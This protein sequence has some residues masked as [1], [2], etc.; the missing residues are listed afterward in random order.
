MTFTKSAV[1]IAEP[2]AAL[3]L[4]LRM[5]AVLLLLRPQGP[6]AVFVAWLATGSLAVLVPAALRSGLLWYVAAAVVATRIAFDWPLADNHMYLLAYWCLAIGLALGAGSPAATLRDAGRWLL[7]GAFGLAVVWKAL[8][9]P[10]FIDGRFFRVTLVVDE[11]FEDVVRLAGG[12]GRDE[13]GRHRAALAPVPPGAELAPDES[14]VEPPQLHRLARVLTIAGLLMEAAVAVGFLLPLPGRWQWARHAL[15]LVFCAA[16]YPI[17][18]V[19]GF[20]WLLLAIG[21]SQAPSSPQ[22]RAAYVGVWV[23]VLAGTELPW[24]R[25]LADALG[26]P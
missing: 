23:G 25:W 3:A 15:L 22:W 24:A 14:L 11:R 9:S 16:T 17:A 20:G 7:A 6:L 21:V 5:T 19:A 4:A 12:M 26:R 13:L 18:P 8:L 10:D 1:R 2:D